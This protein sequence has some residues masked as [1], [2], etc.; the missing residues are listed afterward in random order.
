MNNN[1]NS[2][3]KIMFE[4]STYDKRKLKAK[5]RKDLSLSSSEA[6]VLVEECRSIHNKINEIAGKSFCNETLT[7][8]ETN[9]MNE[10][11]LDEKLK[12]QLWQ[13]AMFAQFR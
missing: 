13:G 1:L 3:V 6:I 10:L 12:T 2:A 4:S 5:L 9:Y 7:N 8:T 11:Q